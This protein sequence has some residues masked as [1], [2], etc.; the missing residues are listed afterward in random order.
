M[1][2]IRE[3]ILDSAQE[4][5]HAI[6]SLA[7]MTID[8]PGLAPADIDLV[9]AHL[10]S[11][12]AALP[13]AATQL[14]DMLHLTQN[15]WHLTMDTMSDTH[16]PSIA[17]DTARLHLYAMRRPAIEIYRHLDAAHQETAHIGATDA[18]E[19]RAPQPAPRFIRPEHR[20]PPSS[21][22]PARPGISR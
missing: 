7:R 11:A 22:G 19:P 20:Q 17:I 18:F 12:V 21:D 9:I 6:R 8:R 5:E 10:A 14:S 4:A 13:Q 3:D 1:T 2:S 16:D 15:D